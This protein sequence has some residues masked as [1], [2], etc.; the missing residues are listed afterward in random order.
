MCALIFAVLLALYV[1]LSATGVAGPYHPWSVRSLVTEVAAALVIAVVGVYVGPYVTAVD[2]RAALGLTRK[3]DWQV[4]D[5]AARRGEVPADA[6]LDGPLLAL[7]RRRRRDLRRIRVTLI[8]V[9]PVVAGLLLSPDASAV[10][11]TCLF[12]VL[13]AAA[14]VRDRALSRR[15]D[16]LELILN[17]RRPAD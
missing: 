1:A 12:A 4:L 5:R 7:V 15:L 13:I 16:R 14:L 6:S 2:E 10:V 17:G 8:V 11:T 3:E 9:M